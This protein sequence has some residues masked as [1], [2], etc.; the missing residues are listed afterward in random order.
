MCNVLIEK[1]K[2]PTLTALTTNN[3]IENKEICWNCCLRVT[4]PPVGKMRMNIVK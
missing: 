4:N 3:E 2:N 1:K